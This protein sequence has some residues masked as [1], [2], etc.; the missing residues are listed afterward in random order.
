MCGAVARAIRFK[1]C[2]GGVVVP[3]YCILPISKT[4]P[5]TTKRPIHQ[6][7]R[8]GEQV[9]ISVFNWDIASKPGLLRF[10]N[11]R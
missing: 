7:I 5:G 6:H 2:H 1:Q 4:S 10:K 11:V 9:K 3:A 8:V